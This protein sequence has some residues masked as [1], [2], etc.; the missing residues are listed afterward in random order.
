MISDLTWDRSPRSQEVCTLV[1]LMDTLTRK[2]ATA[3][4]RGLRKGCLPILRLIVDKCLNHLE[5]CQYHKT[6]TNLG[7]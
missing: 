2:G 1:K 7:S 5:S 3:K 6:A 4:F